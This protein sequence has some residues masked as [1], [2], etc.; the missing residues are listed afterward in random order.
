[1]NKKIKLLVFLLGFGGTSFV[2]SSLL[3]PYRA[4]AEE[5][6]KANIGLNI[7]L[8]IAPIADES[9]IVVGNRQSYLSR[10]ELAVGVDFLY[11]VGKLMSLGAGLM[12]IQKRAELIWITEQGETVSVKN[13]FNYLAIPIPVHFQADIKTGNNIIRPFALLSLEPS[14]F[15]SAKAKAEA[16]AGGESAS[17]EKDITE[18]GLDSGGESASQEKDITG[19]L[20]SLD[21]GIGFGLGIKVLFSGFF[22]S[23][24]WKNIFGLNIVDVK[25]RNFTI[26]LLGAGL[27]F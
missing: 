20:G 3:L 11:D 14:F 23:F 16:K 24:Q 4:L 27:R 25:D 17:Q 5:D 8:P 18:G 13:T 1:M 22:L 21:I 12:Y 10:T 9:I 2:F 6:K 26:T 15:L 19:N 7:G